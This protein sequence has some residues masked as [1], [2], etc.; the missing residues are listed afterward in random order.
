M[1]SAVGRAGLVLAV[2]LTCF[3]VLRAGQNSTEISTT[4]PPAAIAAEGPTTDEHYSWHPVA[5]GGG[6]FI[7]GLSADNKG[8][9]FVA[10]SDVHGAW[11]WQPSHDR[12]ELL[13]TAASMP[14]D[15]LH[16]NGMNEGVYEIAVAPSDAQRIYLAVKGAVYRS[17]DRGGHW[18]RP[19]VSP[20]PKDFDPNGPNRHY[21]P[22]LSI[23][24]ASPDHVL[25]GP[26]KA[27][28]WRSADG[29]STW[30]RVSGLPALARVSGMDTNRPPGVTSWFEPG[31]QGRVW[32][33]VPGR[34]MFLSSDGGQHFEPL[35]NRGEQAP[36]S[37]RRGV[38]TP[39]GAFIGADIAARKLWKYEGRRWTDLTASGA[40][41]SKAWAA[42]AVNPRDGALLA[43]TE[44]GDVSRAGSDGRRWWP[45]YRNSRAGEKDPPWLRISNQGYFATGMVMFDPVVP[46]LMW[47]A[48]G[49]GVFR[50]QA[51]DWPGPLTWESQSR[52]I[53]EI[54]ATDIIS[55]PGI[56]P[57]FAGWDFGIHVKSRLDT[58]STTYGPRERVI[59]AVQ[60][61]AWS[62]ADPSFVATNASDTRQNCCAQDGQSVLAGYSNDAGRTWSRFP[63]LPTPPGT[64]PQD[65]WRMA[66]GAMAVATGDTRNIIWMPSGN[67]AP[68]YTMD[69]GQ[70]WKRVVF[71]GEKLPFTGSHARYM[72]TRKPLAADGARPATFYIV[73]SGNASNAA[74]AGLWRSDD[75]GMRWQHV[76]KGEIA[77]VSGGAAKLRAMPGK[78]GA[79]YFT[80]GVT[81]G[82]DT[83]LRRSL[84]GGA[85]WESLSRVTDVDDIAFGKAA[86]GAKDPAIYLSGKV[87]GRYGIWRSVD[88]AGSWQRLVDFPM[89]RL[90]QVTVIEADKQVFGRVYIGYMGSGFLYGEPDRCRPSDTGERLCSTPD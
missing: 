50:A 71:P 32:A 3:V 22:F 74:L 87:D 82:P 59:I 52:G 65:P 6:G 29:G 62:P 25:F 51:P 35:P 81:G 10:R 80:S 7:T 26:P 89:G 15:A 38:F 76:F 24:P 41:A 61:L 18:W 73:H 75:G 64:S 14:A 13:V 42:V 56:A 4:P 68:F 39:E 9:T 49:F 11:I 33:M 43:F 20:F 55:P 79:L 54:V 40:V 5:I 67:R 45:V 44:G 88:G 72:L 53:E 77:P 86:K 12:W 48:A 36:L 66:Y 84:D 28:L 21:G 17:T 69:R 70:T 37:I 58:Y 78:A 23:D 46:N 83:R 1:K 16:Q 31:A 63:V 85:S 19:A 34:G 57:M 8:M 47:T 60:Q 90:D 27:G 2:G 30:R